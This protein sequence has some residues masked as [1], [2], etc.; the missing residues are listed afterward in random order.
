MKVN[1]APLLK[2]AYVMDAPFSLGSK[3]VGSKYFPDMIREYGLES[4]ILKEAEQMHNICHGYKM[5]QQSSL[6]SQ[7]ENPRGVLCPD[8]R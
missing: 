2:Q 6:C 4:M 7:I 1:L 8:E 5:E 3:L